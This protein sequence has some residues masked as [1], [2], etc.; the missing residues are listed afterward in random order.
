MQEKKN[1][2]ENEMRVSEFIRQKTATDTPNEK[3]TEP[4]RRLGAG[5][6]HSNLCSPQSVNTVVKKNLNQNTCRKVTRDGK[7]NPKT[8]Y[9]DLLLWFKHPKQ[10]QP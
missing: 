6:G 8:T 3:Q 4:R 9:G 5:E 7:K 2:K 10:I 1:K